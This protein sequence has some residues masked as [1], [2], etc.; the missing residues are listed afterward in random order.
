MKKLFAT[1]LAIMMVLSLTACGGSSSGGPN[2]QTYIA[3]YDAENGVDVLNA[4]PEYQFLPAD[5]RAGLAG[6]MRLELTFLIE[7]GTDYTL[8]AHYF[9]PNQTDT[10][11]A[12]YFDFQWGIIGVCTYE[13]GVYTLGAPEMGDASYTAG[14]DYSSNEAYNCFS[15]NGDGTSGS[16]TSDSVSAILEMAAEGTTITVDGGNITGWTVPET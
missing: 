16:W 7:Y 2:E 3:I 5:V 13:N 10:A 1:V 8:V 4:L 14:S 11:A 6:E 9:N 12:D 15:M